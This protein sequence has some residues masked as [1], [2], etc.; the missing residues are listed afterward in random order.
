VRDICATSCEAE[1]L[2]IGSGC[3]SGPG[4][5]AYDCDCCEDRYGDVDEVHG[6]ACWLVGGSRVEGCLMSSLS[7][8]LG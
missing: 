8:V 2:G 6:D 7:V 4:D 1:L 3:F 5:E